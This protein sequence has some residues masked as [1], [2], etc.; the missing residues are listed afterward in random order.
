VFEVFEKI[1][2]QL[3]GHLHFNRISLC[4]WILNFTSTPYD[5]AYFK[6]KTPNLLRNNQLISFG[7]GL[8]HKQ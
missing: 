8:G 1:A 3:F 7:L 4:F 2:L 5:L 6:T